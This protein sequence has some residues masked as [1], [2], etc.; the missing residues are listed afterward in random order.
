L[1]KNEQKFLLL[2]QKAELFFL[3]KEPKTFI[4]L[5]STQ[6]RTGG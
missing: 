4:R 6:H 2:F 3:K 5:V 1:A